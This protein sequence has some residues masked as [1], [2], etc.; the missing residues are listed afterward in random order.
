MSI[1]IVIG[2]SWSGKKQF[3]KERFPN[4]VIISVGDYQ[5]KMLGERKDN[6]I[7]Y[8]EYYGILMNANEQIKEDLVKMISEG[9]EVV[10]AHTLYKAKRRIEYIEAV[11]TVSDEAI[12]IYVMQPSDEQI[13]EFIHADKERDGD[14]SWV[15]AQMREIEFPNVTE[16][17]AHVYVVNDKGVQD[18]SDKPR[19]K[20][21]INKNTKVTLKEFDMKESEIKRDIIGFGDKPFKHICEVC[22]K[23]EIL[24]SKQAYKEGWDYPGEGSVYPTNMFGVLSP[25]TCGKCSIIETAYWAL[26]SGEKIMEQLSEKQLQVV[27]RILQEPEVL[28]ADD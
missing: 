1:N 14:L 10:M 22:G 24:T 9:T 19:E 11:R 20:K 6:M 26:T 17:F 13:L 4:S 7:P 15:K 2:T 5:R 27:E 28:K 21:L 3:I 16:G 25:R 8:P 18:W 23:I 12:D